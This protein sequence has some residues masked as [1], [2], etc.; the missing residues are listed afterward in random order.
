[1]ARAMNGTTDR[2][3][4][5]TPTDLT[6]NWSVAG[7]FRRNTTARS[8]SFWSR[9]TS[10]AA[11][12]QLFIYTLVGDT[13]QVD[14]PFIA[15]IMTSAS[16][17]TDTAWHHVA[18][19]RSGDNWVLYLDGVSDATATNAAA[20]ET[21]GNVE[22]GC[23]T[24]FLGGTATDGDVAEWAGWTAVLDAAEVVALAKG[25]SPLLVRPSSLE[26][27]WPLLGRTSPEVELMNG[28]TAALTGTANATH[29]RMYYP[30]SGMLRRFTTA[31]AGGF[32][33]YPF[34]RGAK[35]GMLAL[36]GGMQ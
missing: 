14:V 36:T 15:A 34:S 27:Y 26:M 4:A 24:A 29:L 21:G 6:S 35:G 2:L 18:V 10:A 20:Q 19:T 22:L 31:V 32:V 23:S 7:W 11:N 9:W 12:R 25:V 28:F 1:M 13:I 8:D 30:D 3:I 17:V 5:T 16:T 33:P